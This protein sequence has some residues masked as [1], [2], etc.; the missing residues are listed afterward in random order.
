MAGSIDFY[1]LIPLNFNVS[2][3]FNMKVDLNFDF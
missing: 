3:D 2:L 1:T